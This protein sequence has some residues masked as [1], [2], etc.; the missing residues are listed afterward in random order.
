MNRKGQTKLTAAVGIALGLTLAATKLD[1]SLLDFL[2]AAT[3]RVG[4]A[5][6]KTPFIPFNDV[7]AVALFRF[8]AMRDFAPAKVAMF[9]AYGSGRGV[10]KDETFALVWLHGAEMQGYVP[11]LYHRSH[12]LD[13]SNASFVNETESEF[14]KAIAR[15]ENY[16]RTSAEIC[17]KAYKDVIENRL[18][19]RVLTRFALDAGDPFIDEDKEDW[20]DGLSPAEI[21]EVDV[22]YFRWHDI[23]Q[24]Y[25]PATEEQKNDCRTLF[26]DFVPASSIGF[27]HT[28][29]CMSY[30]ND[31]GLYSFQWDQLLE[32]FEKW[33]PRNSDGS[34]TEA[35]RL[36]ILVCEPP[37]TEPSSIH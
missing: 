29:N 12:F 14:R 1:A 27:V 17:E 21:R 11:A 10:R 19:Y 3:Y 22:R 25:F 18:I 8:S 20:R 35:A 16:G 23:R 30:F 32:C 24:T 6:W 31:F 28:M 7:A 15:P 5:F 26:D 9:V 37:A 33:H 13:F 36:L 4:V 2:M 34:G